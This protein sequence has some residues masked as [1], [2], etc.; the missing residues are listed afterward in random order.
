MHKSPIISD[1]HRIQGKRINFCQ[2]WGKLRYITLH[3][4]AGDQKL[5]SSMYILVVAL[6]LRGMSID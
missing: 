1:F 5:C 4:P 6:H 2:S 3:M